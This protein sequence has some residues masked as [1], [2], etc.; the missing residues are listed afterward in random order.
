MLDAARQAPEKLETARLC[1]RRFR[2]GD[3]DDL[4]VICRDPGVERYMGNRVPYGREGTVRLMGWF[5]GHWQLRGYGVYALERHEDGV[6]AGYCG[7]IWPERNIYKGP[8]EQF[9]ELT[10]AVSQDFRGLGYAGEA[11]RAV[12]D[13][14]FADLALPAVLCLAEQENFASL[15]VAEK[16]GAE[17]VRALENKGH[18]NFL[19]RFRPGLLPDPFV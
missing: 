7:L 14:A 8:D 15:R 6:L 12:L 10:W 5:M 4:E 18:A 16:L 2:P 11:A 9:P 3:L 19:M 1:L 17:R 13:M